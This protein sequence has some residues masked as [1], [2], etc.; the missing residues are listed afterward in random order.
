MLRILHHIPFQN[1]KRQT[2]V[3]KKKKHTHTHVANLLT[4]LSRIDIEQGSQLENDIRDLYLLPQD[5]YTDVIA[6]ARG[7]LRINFTSIFKVFTKLKKLENFENTS[8]INP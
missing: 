3:G 2:A 5:L 6:W 7:Q 8:K 4:T 1:A